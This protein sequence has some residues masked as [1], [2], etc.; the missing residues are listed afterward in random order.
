MSIDGKAAVVYEDREYPGIHRRF[1]ELCGSERSMSTCR[2]S[3][4]S[5]TLS[6]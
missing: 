3:L 6:C 1:A 4:T 2:S 5:R